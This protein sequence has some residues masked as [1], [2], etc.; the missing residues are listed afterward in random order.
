VHGKDQPALALPATEGARVEAAERPYADRAVDP[1]RIRDR[2]DKGE[3]TIPRGTLLIIDDADHLDP[4]LLR[5]F[6]E[7]ATATN[8]KLLL[9]HSPTLNRQ[10]SHTVVQALADALPRAQRISI[11]P[12]EQP[13]PHRTATERVTTLLTEARAGATPRAKE[14]TKLI[15]RRNRILDAHHQTQAQQE[16]WADRHAHRQHDRD[17]GGLEI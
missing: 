10:P 15:D 9:V 13:Q 7:H 17:R 1:R 6:T 12:A 5:Y 3:L 11:S 2:I 14:A 16:R 4:K 8:T